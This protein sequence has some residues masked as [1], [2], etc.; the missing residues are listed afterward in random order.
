MVFSQ[1]EQIGV[2]ERKLDNFGFVAL[3]ETEAPMTEGPLWAR[4]ADIRQFVEVS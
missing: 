3:A 1:A 4:K 2:H